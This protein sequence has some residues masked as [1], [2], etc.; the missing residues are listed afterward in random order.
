ML[1]VRAYYCAKGRKVERR[2]SPEVRSPP[3][4]ARRHV[5]SFL[6]QKNRGQKNW[7]RLAIRAGQPISP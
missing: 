7:R 4:W 2:F 1:Q 3:I 5:R 6:K